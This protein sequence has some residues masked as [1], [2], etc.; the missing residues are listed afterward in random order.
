MGNQR[1]EKKETPYNINIALRTF[2]AGS[3]NGIRW[4]SW[5]LS[6]WGGYGRSYLATET[7][8]TPLARYQIGGH[9]FPGC[10]YY[11][12]YFMCHVRLCGKLYV[13]R[14]VWVC[15]IYL[16]RA[17]KLWLDFWRIFACVALLWFIY[18]YFL[19]QLESPFRA[20]NA[21]AAA[22]SFSR[23]FCAAISEPTFHTHYLSV[24]GKVLT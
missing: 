15:V 20:T 22:D 6:G 16:A 2:C 4:G 7:I 17:Q 8:R 10:P 11:I 23:T 18:F 3:R 21:A 13:W 24:Q 1:E 9:W 19:C 14:R 5:Q 12:R